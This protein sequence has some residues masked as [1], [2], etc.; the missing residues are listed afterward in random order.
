MKN[1]HS[2]KIEFTEFQRV[3]LEVGTIIKAEEFP[4]AKKPAYKLWIQFGENEIKKSS[5]QITA[6]YTLPSLI[7][8]Q[9]I[10][11]TNLKPRQIGPFISEVLV[12]GFADAN[13][14]II[15][16]VPDKEVPN[17]NVLH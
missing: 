8:K 17:G 12:T 9:V 2:E 13:N 3:I 7:N 14:N 15:L 6:N 1:F 4:E 10:C 11:V 5:A 16:A